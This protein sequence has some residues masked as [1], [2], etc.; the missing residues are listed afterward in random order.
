[1]STSLL[2]HAFGVRGYDY[3]RTRYE[4][5]AVI[6][7]IRQE[8]ETCRCSSC[9][10][11]RVIRRGRATRRFRSLPIGDRA[12]FVDLPIPR[13][14]CLACGAVRQVEVPFADPLSMN[15]NPYA[16]SEPE[17][18]RSLRVSWRG[19]FLQDRPDSRFASGTFHF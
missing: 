13:V 17:L 15:P 4:G 19:G 9:G 6:F 5:G 3:T 7:S 10:S 11:A 16:V 1:M 18:L 8:T 14:Q 12:T 2:Y